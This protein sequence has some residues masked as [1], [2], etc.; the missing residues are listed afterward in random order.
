MNQEHQPPKHIAWEKIVALLAS[1]I[2]F[3]IGGWHTAKGLEHYDFFSSKYGSYLIAGMIIAL[4]STFYASAVKGSFSS[5]LIYIVFASVTFICNVNWFYPHEQ[6]DALIR[7]ELRGHD[8]AFIALKEA[9]AKQVQKEDIDPFKKKIEGMISEL[10]AQV[11]DHGCGPLAEEKLVAIEKTLDIP[12]ITRLKNAKGRDEWNKAADEY[13]EIL[14]KA[15]SAALSEKA[16]QDNAL[17]KN[18]LI[19]M[20][21]TKQENFSKRIKDTLT[22][23]DRLHVPPPYVEEIVMAH[24]EICQQAE[25]LAG[26]E[27]MS[28]VCDANYSSANKDIGRFSHTFASVSE[29]FANGGT[30]M[31]LFFVFLIDYFIPLSLYFLTRPKK[32]LPR[33]G[34]KV[35]GKDMPIAAR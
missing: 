16:A 2:C 35:G 26:K 10:Q 4:L 30:K 6:G 21:K 27:T 19:E 32:D 8:A 14:N 15:L 1:F 5:L 12:Q 3:A 20:V 22:S 13:G 31:I 17:N 7:Q 33:S 23:P 11:R 34:W 29:N 28:T 9:V 25:A 24:H 18:T